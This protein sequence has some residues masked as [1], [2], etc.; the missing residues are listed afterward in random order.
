[1]LSSAFSPSL[2]VTV[3]ALT[4]ASVVTEYFSRESLDQYRIPSLPCPWNPPSS[5]LLMVTVGEVRPASFLSGAEIPSAFKYSSKLSLLSNFHVPRNV[6][7]WIIFLLRSNVCFY[8]DA[9]LK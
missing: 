3:T 5:P 1:M 8:A 2:K 4:T 6:S 7:I 9:E